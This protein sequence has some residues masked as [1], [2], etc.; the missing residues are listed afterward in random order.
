MAARRDAEMHAIPVANDRVH[1]EPAVAGLPL[2]RVLVV[3]DAGHQVPRIAAVMAPE[4]GRRL[5]TA[6]QVLLAAPGPRV[7]RCWRARVRRPSGMP[8]PTSFP[9][10]SS[11]YPSNA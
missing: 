7:T 11:P 4:Q 9:G 6:P 8:A 10:S 5:D 3:A 2:A 1:A